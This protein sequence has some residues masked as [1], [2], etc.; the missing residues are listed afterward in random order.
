MSEALYA[1]GLSSLSVDLEADGDDEDD[2]DMPEEQTYNVSRQAVGKTLDTLTLSF[3]GQCPETTITSVDALV[4]SRTEI[5]A[6][7]PSATQGE[8]PPHLAEPTSGTTSSC[9]TSLTTSTCARRPRRV[10]H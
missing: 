10:R 7:D 9:I 5:I 1:A 6:L 8:P 4:G 2:D 3:S